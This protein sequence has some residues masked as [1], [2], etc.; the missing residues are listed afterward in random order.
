MDDETSDAPYGAEFDF[1][2]NPVGLFRDQAFPIEPGE[3][4]YEPY[5]GPGHYE[6][7]TALGS[8][9]EVICMYMLNGQRVSF[10]VLSC[11]RYGIL[12]LS[13]FQ[14]EPAIRVELLAVLPESDDVFM[15]TFLDAF[16]EHQIRTRWIADGAMGWLVDHGNPSLQSFLQ[17]RYPLKVDQLVKAVRTYRRA[18]PINLP[19]RLV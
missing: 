19:L 6:M 18:E 7:Q 17:A 14:I 4:A 1:E 15:L 9:T 10:Q 13:G 8:G 3:Y 11:P 2:S 16:G 12:N 5:R